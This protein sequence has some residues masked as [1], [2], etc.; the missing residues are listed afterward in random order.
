MAILAIGEKVLADMSGNPA[1]PDPRVSMEI[2]EE[3]FD[4]T[5]ASVIRE[6]AR[7]VSKVRHHFV[8]EISSFRGMH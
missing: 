1:F 4:E 8:N 6:V 7:K 2:L 5:T 3:A